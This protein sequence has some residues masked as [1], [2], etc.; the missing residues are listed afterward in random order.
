MTLKI[1]YNKIKRS[2]NVCG[3]SLVSKIFE[4]EILNNSKICEHRNYSGRYYRIYEDL[5]G[6]ENEDIIRMDK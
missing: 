5:K 2:R 1:L 4:Q 6:T 3:F